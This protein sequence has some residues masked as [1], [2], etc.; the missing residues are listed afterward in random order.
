LE[1]E[2][3]EGR[4]KETER[5]LEQGLHEK[6]ALLLEGEIPKA[7][8]DQRTQR[9]TEL[10]LERIRIPL[11]RYLEMVGEDE[12]AFLARMADQSAR[13]IKVE[14]ALECV[15]RK[16]NLE[17]SEEEVEAEYQR[18]ADEYNVPLARAKYN[19]P[20]EEIQKDLG[21]E[22]AME[23]VKAHAIITQLPEEPDQAE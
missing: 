22:K 7:M 8:F 3:A 15:A 14:L 19:V 18:L 6:L 10:F 12:A 16:E 23:F 1:K 4:Q 21:R 2:L 5:A 17:S 13:Q 9:N 20:K 11:E